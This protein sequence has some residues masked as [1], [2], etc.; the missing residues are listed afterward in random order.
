[1]NGYGLNCWTLSR[2]QK[3]TGFSKEEMRLRNLALSRMEKEILMDV[4]VD[5]P[6]KHADRV[7][8]TFWHHK[9]N[10]SVPASLILQAQGSDGFGDWIGNLCKGVGRFAAAKAYFVSLEV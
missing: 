8:A 4:P 7:T 1:M 9:A 2:I 6:P 10:R 3:D 5:G